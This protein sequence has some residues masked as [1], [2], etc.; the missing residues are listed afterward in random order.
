MEREAHHDCLQRP[1]EN[2]Q[3]KLLQK[4]YFIKHVSVH[5]LR[6]VSN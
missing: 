1:V 5:C 2:V 3:A 6:E 4:L